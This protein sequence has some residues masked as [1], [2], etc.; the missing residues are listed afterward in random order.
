M[1]LSTFIVL[2]YTLVVR[3]HDRDD[4]VK[5]RYSNYNEKYIVLKKLNWKESPQRN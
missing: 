5:R 4:T 3:S 2:L 1:N